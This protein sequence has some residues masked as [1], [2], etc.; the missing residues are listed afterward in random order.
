MPNNAPTRI[1]SDTMGEVAVP[2]DRLWGAQTQRSI[3]N[4][5][6]GA[7]TMP[8]GLVRALGIQKRAAAAANKALGELEA[9]IAEANYRSRR[10]GCRRSARHRVSSR[11]LAD[12]FRARNR[13]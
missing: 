8:L 10:R 5:P 1:E 6:I 12:R 3:E 2:A 9:S 7:E 4:F 13:T 11:R